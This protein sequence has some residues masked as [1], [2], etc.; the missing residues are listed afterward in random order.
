[1][2][3]TQKISNR[4]LKV[5]A[6]AATF[7]LPSVAHADCANTV[8]GGVDCAKGDLTGTALNTSVTNI[9]NLIIFSTGI[10]AV[11][12]IIIGGIRYVVSQ[13]DEKSIESAKNTI[14][15]AVVGLIVAVLAYAIVNF[16]LTGLTK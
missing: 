13:G 12:V 11:I 2:A 3:L 5:A 7:M 14:L 16:V 6:V 1:M 9:I 10:I 8:Q 4:A 15:Y